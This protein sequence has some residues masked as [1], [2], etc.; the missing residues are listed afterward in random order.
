MKLWKR[1]SAAVIA[2]LRLAASPPLRTAGV[3]ETAA[4]AAFRSVRTAAAFLAPALRR[5]IRDRRR[6]SG[7]PLS[8]VAVTLV[9]DVQFS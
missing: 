9:R 5:P 1:A 8:P 2:T 6:N 7:N 4:T 3:R